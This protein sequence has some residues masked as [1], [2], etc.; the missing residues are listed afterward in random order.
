MRALLEIRYEI[1]IDGVGGFRAIDDVT[2]ANN[3]ERI[4]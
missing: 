4:L 3:R 1:T 2:M